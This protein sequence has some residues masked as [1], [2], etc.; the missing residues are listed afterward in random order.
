M[1]ESGVWVPNQPNLITFVL[2]DASGGEVAGLGGVFNVLISKGTGAFVAGAGTQGEKGNGWYWYEATAGEADT[3]GPVSVVAQGF[4]TIQQ[5]LE[6]VCGVRVPNSIQFTYTLTDSVTT[7]PLDGAEVWFT[8]DAV[9]NKIVWYG[10][11]DAFGVARDA[12]GDLPL[13]RPGTYYVWRS[14][15]GYSFSDPDTEV[16]S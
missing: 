4:G 5:N 3:I 8:V 11:T 12:G 13:L 2:V 1:L 9:G 14:L 6:Y 15:A 16:V 10:V 7:L